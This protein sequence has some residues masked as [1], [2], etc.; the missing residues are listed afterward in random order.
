M[1]T[2]VPDLTLTVLGSSPSWPNPGG[3]C[4]G[5]LV[6]AGDSR[7]LLDCGPG[8]VGRVRAAVDLRELRAVVISH[9]H[10]DHYLDL[11]VLRHAIK[12]GKLRGEPLDVYVPPGGLGT[13]RKLGDA[14]A[15]DPAF[16]DGALTIR[17]YDPMRTLAFGSMS[18]ELRQVVH[19]VPCFAM[20][21]QAA[22]RTLV[23][24]GDAAPCEALVEHARGADVLLAEAAIRHPSD[25]AADPA[26]RGH[27]TPAEAGD[28]ARRAGVG[29][30]LLTHAPIDADDPDR[31]ACEAAMA[32]AGPVERVVDGRTYAI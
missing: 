22:G 30:L 9:M 20:Q 29:R 1:E 27:L 14:L 3:A 4:S 11:V 7:V 28:M 10:P 31:V 18:V 24:S 32:F 19:Y 16:F 6:A 2:P 17:E 12:Y 13:L 23:F 25:D 8:V 15:S 5:Y 21:V 26:Q